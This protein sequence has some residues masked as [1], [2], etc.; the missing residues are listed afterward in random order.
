MRGC[1]DWYFVL[2]PQDTSPQY[3][4]SASRFQPHEKKTERRRVSV[5]SLLIISFRAFIGDGAFTRK[6]CKV[7]SYVQTLEK[8]MICCVGKE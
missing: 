6:Y 8:P 5:L 2:V 7:F 1:S 3:A 4:K